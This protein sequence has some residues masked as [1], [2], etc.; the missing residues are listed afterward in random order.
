MDFASSFWTDV[1]NWAL[2]DPFEAGAH[3]VIQ[4]RNSRSIDWRIA[5]VDSRSATL[6]F[7]VPGAVA[8]LIRRFEDAGSPSRIT[9]Q[10]SSRGEHAPQYVASFG[11]ALEMGIPAGMKE[12][13]EAIDSEFR[14]QNGN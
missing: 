3:G 8:E 9:Q 14:E 12:L 7:P 6:E 4:S 11:R 2:D 5:S 10:A 13:I 1:T